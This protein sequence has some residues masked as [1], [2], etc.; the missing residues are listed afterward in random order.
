M[1][2]VVSATMKQLGLPDI[3]ACAAGSGLFESLMPPI[4]SEWVDVCKAYAVTKITKI[5]DGGNIPVE[6]TLLNEHRELYKRIPYEVGNDLF[7]TVVANV[8]PR[9]SCQRPPTRSKA[10]REVVQIPSTCWVKRGA[11]RTSTHLLVKLYK[12][13]NLEPIL[14]LEFLVLRSRHLSTRR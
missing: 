14:M 12:I 7:S 5:T 11:E 3:L 9:T 4:C 10:K 1:Y 8:A 13:D 6:T 2:L